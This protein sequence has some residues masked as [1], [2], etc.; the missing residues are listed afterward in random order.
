MPEAEITE[1]NLTDGSIDII[2]I[3]ALSGLVPSKSEGRRAVQQGGVSVDGEKIADI[4]QSYTAEQL[5]GDG[6]IVKR[7]K[8]NFRKVFMK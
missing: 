4:A 6:I 3:L 5:R 2:S 7:G 8:K 1:D